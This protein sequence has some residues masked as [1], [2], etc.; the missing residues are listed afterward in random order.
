MSL[1]HMTATPRF[2]STAFPSQPAPEIF[3]GS[4]E[5]LRQEVRALRAEVAT[6]HRRLLEVDAMQHKEV[7]A[8]RLKVDALTR[9]VRALQA[10]PISLFGC[11]PL[12]PPLIS[13]RS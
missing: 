7:E 4:D 12:L 5:V 10:Q 8:L 2:T 1:P 6:L 13:R 11:E 9:G 3:R